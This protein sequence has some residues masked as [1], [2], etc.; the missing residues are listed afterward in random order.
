MILGVKGH[1]MDKKYIMSID[2]GTTGTRVFFFDHSGT[3][4]T[5]AYREITQIY[6]QPGWVEQKPQEY[7][8]TTLACTKEAMEVGSI[9]PEEIQAIGITC[10]RETTILWDRITGEPFYNA[11]VWQ[12]RQTADICEGMKARGYEKLVR[13]KT[14]L[15]IDAYFSASKIRFILDRI[16]NA[17]ELISSG[18]LC[19]GNIDSYLIWKLTGGAS[20]VEDYSNAARTL[21]VNIH[22]LEWDD[23]LL[24]MLDIPRE[25]LPEL[26][27]SSGV[28]AVTDRKIFFGQ[29]IPIAGDAGDQSAATFGQTC[30]TPGSV[31]N[32]YGTALAM[33]MNIGKR[34]I[35]SNY[36]LI[37]DL[38]W[39]L[40]KPEYSFEAVNFNGGAVIQWL[41]DGLKIISN[42]AESTAK[43]MK[44]PDT[45]GVY[46]VP[47]FTGLCTPYWDMYARGTIT[48]ITRGT[49]EEHIC[50][51][52]IE[53][54]AYQSRDSLESMSADAADPIR[55]LRVD[56]GATKSEF[57]MQFQADV[58]G[59]PIEI[60]QVAEMAALGAAYLAGL[61]V[62]FWKDKQEIEKHWK[63]AKRYEP[64]MTK[65]QRDHLY[66]GWQI[67]V[68][69][70]LSNLEKTN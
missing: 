23:E 36:G 39:V 27:P 26:K 67:A 45:G 9:S 53:S 21:F 28:M 16:P 63:L 5:S 20:H 62:G 3:V 70:S 41:R 69:R 68:K 58:L 40:D 65:D 15:S 44:V 33:M 51:A 60:P 59:I 18:R 38:L 30:F 46:I 13:E 32:T 12:S 34:P 55:S 7:W 11:I 66:A 56:G 47:A 52:A 42:S 31:K 19:F 6:P 29:E 43:A 22:T 4:H 57:L 61:G 35:P 37:T 8:E 25:I 48:G 10:Q 14:G 1:R 17:A 64:R 54:M 24:A 2:Q 50:R 49:T